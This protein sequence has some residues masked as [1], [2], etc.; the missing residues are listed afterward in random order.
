MCFSFLFLCFFQHC[1]ICGPLDSTVSEDAGFES[2]TFTE[3]TL[4]VES[5]C[6]LGYISSNVKFCPEYISFRQFCWIRNQLFWIRIRPC[7]SCPFP[8]QIIGSGFLRTQIFARIFCTKSCAFIAL[9]KDK[10]EIF[11]YFFWSFCKPYRH[12]GIFC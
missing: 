2:R 9:K 4:A 12:V 3:F 5:C 11:G 6:P 8:F 7:K 1:F 10:H